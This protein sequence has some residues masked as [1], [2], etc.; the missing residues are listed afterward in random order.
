MAK[1]ATTS[2]KSQK[3]KQAKRPPAGKA[4]PAPKPTPR[5]VAPK[6]SRASSTS[7]DAIATLREELDEARAELARVASDENVARRDLEARVSSAHSVELRLRQELE[8]LHVDLR[9]ALADLEIVRADRMRAEHKIEAAA[10][11]SADARES[12]RLATHASDHARDQM[13]ELRDELDKLRHENETLR[14]HL[15]AANEELKLK[16]E[17]QA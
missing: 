6:R 10:R 2:K 13:L 4:R 15:H 14:R 17:P 16:R 8:A 1:K 3:S 12:E 5:K 11:D 7:A 9:T